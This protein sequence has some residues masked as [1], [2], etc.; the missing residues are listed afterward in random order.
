MKTPDQRL[1]RIPSLELKTAR[2]LEKDKE[3]LF[4]AFHDD[5]VVRIDLMHDEDL[6]SIFNVD[7]VMQHTGYRSSRIT[8][9]GVPTILGLGR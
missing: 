6:L 3:Y 9:I 8:G 2:E 1:P 7:T 4:S 5:S